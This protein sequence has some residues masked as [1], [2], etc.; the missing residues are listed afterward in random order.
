[1]NPYSGH[2]GTEEMTSNVGNETF[3]HFVQKKE[4]LIDPD[5]L[6]M[7]SITRLQRVGK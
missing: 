5:C 4:R 6:L 1:M 2:D 3:H 7:D